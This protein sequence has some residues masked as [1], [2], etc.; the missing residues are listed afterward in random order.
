MFDI[1]RK[2]EY[3]SW[4]KRGIAKDERNSLKEIQDGYALSVLSGVKGKRILEMGGGNSRVLQILAP[5]NEC[6]N[7]DKLEGQHLGPTARNFVSVSGVKLVRAFMGDFAKELPDNYFDYVFSI[8]VVEHVPEGEAMDNM[9]RDVARVLKPDGMA[10]HAIDIYLF[11]AADREFK[12]SQYGRKR[13][14]E[15]LRFADRP[16]LDLRMRVPPKI[17]PDQSYSCR[18][19]T[20]SDVM[21]YRRN[22]IAP[23]LASWRAI[24]HSCSI[25]AEW[26]RSAGAARAAAVGA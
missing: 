10:F 21:M 4:I 13:I 3:W 20:H 26:V 6:W 1:I 12:G 17:G 18:Y 22:E 14:S 5:D 24:S 11:D 15:Y 23:A 16:D 25:K 9:F 19:A 7:V 2:A 8:S